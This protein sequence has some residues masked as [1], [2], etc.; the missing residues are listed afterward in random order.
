MRYDIGTMPERRQNERTERVVHDQPGPV[1]FR[2]GRK[3]GKVCHLEK[4]IA[5]ALAVEDP[6]LRGHSGPDCL[7][8]SKV[9]ESRCYPETWKK[10]REQ[11]V[12]PTVY[13]TAR[14]Y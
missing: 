3:G 6:C 8:V 5:Y 11:R 12:R 4:R 2:H 14:H 9:D 1:L 7:F 13:G 10:I